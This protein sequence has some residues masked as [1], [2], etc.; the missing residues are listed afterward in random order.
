MVNHQGWFPSATLSFNVPPNVSV[1]EAV[2]T[3]QRAT[4]ELHLPRSIATSFQGS[5]Q[6]FQNSLRSHAALDPR[7]FARTGS[8]IG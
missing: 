8:V 6:A 3:I 4:R 2:T 1:G 7:C 5:A